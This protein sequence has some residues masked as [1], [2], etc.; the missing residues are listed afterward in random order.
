[1][2]SCYKTECFL[3]SIDRCAKFCCLNLQWLNNITPFTSAVVGR[4]ACP[5]ALLLPSGQVGTTWR[6]AVPCSP[7]LAHCWRVTPLTSNRDHRNHSRCLVH[8]LSYPWHKT[9]QRGSQVN[10]L[11]SLFCGLLFLSLILRYFWIE[12]FSDQFFCGH[13]SCILFIFIRWEILTGLV[14]PNLAICLLW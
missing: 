12:D 14:I 2:Y 7:L 5:C 13:K 8:Q 6:S 4:V 1:M 11:F 3:Y 9:D 10:W